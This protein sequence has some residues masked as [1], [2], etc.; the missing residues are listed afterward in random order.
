MNNFKLCILCSTKICNTNNQFTIHL[1][2]NHNTTKKNYIIL[3]EYNNIHPKCQ[4]GYCN[5]D[6]N[7]DNRYEIFRTINIEHKNHKWL[8]L[9]YIKK[10]GIP[11]CKTCNTSVKFNRG[12]PN[13]YCSKKCIPSNWNQKTINKNV[14]Q[15]YNVDN[16]SQLSDVKKKVK[17]SYT[18]DK[19]K[20]ALHKGKTIRNE[21]YKN[22]WFDIDK[23]RK[24]NIERYGVDSVQKLEKNKIASA[25][26]IL[27]TNFFKIKKYKDTNLNYQSSYEKHFLE[28][29]EQIGIIKNIKN[30]NIFKYSNTDTAKFYMRTDFSIDNYEIEIKSSYILKKQ[31]G[32][33]VLNLKRKTVEATEKQ[34]I[35][36]LDK[37]YNEFLEIYNKKIN[38]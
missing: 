28:L 14:K 1:K 18:T 6:A 4:C 15:K 27:N 13:T 26:R 9:Q 22:G 10:Y 36:I 35:F 31:G 37:D 34:Y 38:H 30:G 24:T 23:A 17:K 29:C 21:K 7:F 2:N 19:R 12:K 5:D 25:K 3:T 33:S 32:I 16:I 20:M 8:K 11:V